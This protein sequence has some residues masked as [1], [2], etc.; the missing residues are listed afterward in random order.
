[1]QF[2]DKLMRSVV[3]QRLVPGRVSAD[4]CGGSTVAWGL[5]G[6][7]AGA[8]LGQVDTPVMC[9]DRCRGRF[10]CSSSSWTRSFTC[11]LSCICSTRWSMPLLCC[12]MGV[13][14][15]QFNRHLARLR[16]HARQALSSSP[17]PNWTPHSARSS[18]HARQW[19]LIRAERSSNGSCRS[20]RALEGSSLPSCFV[21]FFSSFV[22]PLRPLGLGLLARGRPS[23]VITDAGPAS[24]RVRLWQGG[25]ASTY[26]RFRL[27]LLL[28]PVLVFL[29][30]VY[31]DTLKF[32]SAPGLSGGRGAM[33]MAVA[34]SARLAFFRGA[35][36]AS[37]TLY[38]RRF[39]FVP[40]QRWSIELPATTVAEWRR[41][42]S[43]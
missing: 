13:P 8:V 15:V 6:D 21:L 24:H 20:H 1:M 22:S 42:R 3:V 41:R 33:E 9:N 39:P 29:E 38:T 40:V 31:W 14:Q 7:S 36:C 5:Y 34:S 11:P 2:L 17:G 27:P 37:C 23:D 10:L 18:N 28:F 25:P 32:A 4:N 26:C 35:V 12:G 30:L 19:H 43:L 16:D